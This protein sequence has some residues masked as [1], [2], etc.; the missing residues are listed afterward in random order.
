MSNVL[1]A[2]ALALIFLNVFAEQ[3]GLPLPSQPVL[4]LAGAL[5]LNGQLQLVPLLVTV[6]C[7]F[8]I[9]D[10]VWFQAGR[11][12]GRRIM[13]LLCRISLSPD[14]CVRQS[15]T[16][17]RRWGGFSLV[18]TR[19]IPGLS[20]I[21]RPLAGALQLGWPRF[22]LLNTLGVLLWSGAW[23]GL[24]MLL[25]VPIGHAV[26]ALGDHGS[27]AA[28]IVIVALVAYIGLRW[29]LRHR[30]FQQL[31]IVRISADQLDALK[32]SGHPVVIVDLRSAL[33]RETD[34]RRIPGAI[35][36]DLAEVDRNL[37]RLPTDCDIVFY[38]SCPHEAS[39]ALA[40][41][42]LMSLGYT[43][44]RPL[45]GGLDGWIG[46]G[47]DVEGQRLDAGRPLFESAG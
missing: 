20:R 6:F 12:N 33:V 11:M 23:I 15:E 16:R 4:I 40:A 19:F 25:H 22:L 7:A 37:Q 2:H 42:K 36:I 47:Y 38:C 46:A 10:A 39:A 8:M 9:G 31:R 28:E 27:L 30:F 29:Y 24:G 26:A 13:S 5:A 3:L 34:Q 45:L 35:M 43:R 1:S 17:Y 21:A 14:S 44:V 41:R 32:A 18:I